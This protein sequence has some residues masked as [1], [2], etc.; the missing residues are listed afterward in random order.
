MNGVR[1]LDKQEPTGFEIDLVKMFKSELTPELRASFNKALKS[2]FTSRY[3]IV[4]TGLMRSSL[5]LQFNAR[6]VLVYF[7]PKKIIGKRRKGQVVKEYYP[8]YL[9]SFP[10][11]ARW[12]ENLVQ[13]FLNHLKN[14]VAQTNKANKDKKNQIYTLLLISLLAELRKEKKVKK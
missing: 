5:T 8:Q 2:V 3:M 4:D 12:L 10:Q 11:H 1:I 7:D 13:V 6:R 9:S 14:S